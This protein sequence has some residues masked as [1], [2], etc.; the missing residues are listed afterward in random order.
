MDSISAR[1]SS[2]LH[3]IRV[4]MKE[5][6]MHA[7]SVVRTFQ[8]CCSEAIQQAR[9]VDNDRFAQKHYHKLFVVGDL[10]SPESET[11]MPRTGSSADWREHPI[12][13]TIPFDSGVHEVNVQ[14]AD[15]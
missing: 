9:L 2:G 6:T 15:Q 3:A 14:A 5:R 4:G 8:N 10:H 13:S 1:L 7:G 12:A 11:G